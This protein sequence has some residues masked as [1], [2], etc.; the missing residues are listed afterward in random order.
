MGKVKYFYDEGEKVWS[1][2][3]NKIVYVK[4]VMP[5]EK[6]A[7][8]TFKNEG[9]EE[10]KKVNLWDIRPFRERDVVYFSKVQSGATIPTKDKADAGYDLY[11]CSDEA[12]MFAPGDIKL[13]PT[14]IASAMSPKYRIKIRERGST[15]IKGFAVRSGVVDSS[16]RGEIFVAINNTSS[17]PFEITSAVEEVEETE[18]FVRWPMKK[19]IAQAVVEICPNVNVKEVSYEELKK[20]ESRRGTGMLGSTGK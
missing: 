3:D 19:A 5:E 18:D 12:I 7:I 9:K 4:E 14:G 17:K 11:C 13:V 8:V 1:K 6:S 15:G 2:V 16:F 20:M 10:E